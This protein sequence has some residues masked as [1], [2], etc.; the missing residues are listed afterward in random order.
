MAFPRLNKQGRHGVPLHD[1]GTE[2]RRQWQVARLD[3]MRE[4]LDKSKARQEESKFNVG[5]GLEEKAVALAPRQCVNWALGREM[6]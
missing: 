2:R 6:S 3:Q 1:M 4:E 5:N